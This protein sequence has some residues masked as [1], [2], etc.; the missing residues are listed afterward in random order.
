MWH[1]RTDGDYVYLTHSEHKGT[2]Q[3]KADYEGFVVDMFDIGN[4][5]IATAFAF[6]ENLEEQL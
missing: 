1:V 4:E 5:S 3:V 2:I 6:Y